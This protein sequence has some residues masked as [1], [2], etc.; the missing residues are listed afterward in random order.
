MKKKL[1]WM[2]GAALLIGMTAGCGN[3]GDPPDT[4]RDSSG[5]S[6][7]EMES[8]T[9]WQSEIVPETVSEIGKLPDNVFEYKTGYL[10]YVNHSF[11]FS[12][13]FPSEFSEENRAYVPEEGLCLQNADG[14]AVLTIEKAFQ[15]G[16][17]WKD[18]VDL[19]KKKYPDGKT[20]VTDTK[21]VVCKTKTKDKSGN[22]VWASLKA[23]LTD[24]GYVKVV[25]VYDEE[26]KDRYESVFNQ[27][28]FE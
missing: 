10:K 7:E 8:K 1:L 23:R 3:A 13:V 21:L 15:P 2:L 20:I 19:L 22:E 14:K 28:S 25:L 12:V 18:L 27:I 4:V 26:N 17:G 16:I 9:S 5:A 6:V 24:D 11:G